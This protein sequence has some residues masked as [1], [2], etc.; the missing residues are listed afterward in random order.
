MK[1]MISKIWM[2]FAAIIALTSCSTEALTERSALGKEAQI[3]VGDFV[4]FQDNGSRAATVIG[5]PDA[6]K[7]AWAEGDVLLLQVKSDDKVYKT[8]KLSY[9]G[10][11]WQQ[12]GTLYVYDGAKVCATYAPNYGFDTEGNVVLQSGKMAGTDEYVS[13]ETPITDGNDHVT[14]AF[15]ENSRGYSRLRI[16]GEAGQE[17][18]L[19]AKGFTPVGVS[20]S[21][22]TE[23]MYTLTADD[24]G[25][26][27]LYG[28]FSSDASVFASAEN[29]RFTGEHT[30]TAATDNGKSYAMGIY[31]YVTF[32]S[33]GVQKMKFA[34]QNG[35]SVQVN[36]LQYSINGGE[37]KKLE[38]GVQTEEFG[39][40]KGNLRLRGRNPQDGT[41]KGTI[42]FSSNENLVDC[43]GDI[44]T[45]LQYL[46]Y[47]TQPVG[48]EATFQKLFSDCKALR[49][50]DQ[51]F[52]PI[53]DLVANGLYGSMFSQCISLTD[54]PELPATALTFQ[55]YN[56]MFLGC[57]K[58]SKVV[59]LATDART[60]LS[61]WLGNT[62]VAGSDVTSRT[63]Q[64]A[65]KEVYE[66][67]KSN[68]PT[69]WQIGQCNVID[70]DGNPISEE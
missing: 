7:T 49:S 24:N 62:D 28:S 16:A 12:S 4:A 38:V 39:G 53:K 21:D 40:D 1:T 57:R 22:D 36:L 61:W 50:V 42:S 9:D 14:I 3:T 35:M 41:G 68:L 70:K 37:W 17:I 33:G 55:C 43:T 63:L 6:G 2:A 13:T 8:A 47:K 31:P 45:L 54:A 69:I 65:S 44:R 23:K 52:L 15:T 29:E 25:N 20:G 18:S 67:I 66:Q 59:M 27:F 5:T 11:Q 58:L 46:K 48:E 10:S 26:I 30:F 60:G 56:D 64:L 32:K 34:G 19:K 51:N